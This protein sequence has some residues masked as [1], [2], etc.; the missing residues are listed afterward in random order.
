MWEELGKAF[1]LM[2]VLEG[3]IPFLYPTRWRHLVARPCTCARAPAPRTAPAGRGRGDPGSARVLRGASSGITA[4]DLKDE[5]PCKPWLPP[6]RNDSAWEVGL[7]GEGGHGTGCKP[8]RGAD[9]GRFTP[10]EPL[11]GAAGTRAPVSAAQDTEAQKPQVVSDRAGLPPRTA[12]SKPRL[13]PW[14]TC[15]APCSAHPTPR[16]PAQPLA[17]DPAQACGSL[18]QATT[19]GC[20]R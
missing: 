20:L 5:L 16:L 18:Y 9:G 14:I 7:S 15:P 6:N 19:L 4:S 3:I 13:G 17:R 8:G 2:L 1:C 10:W 12:R 11:R